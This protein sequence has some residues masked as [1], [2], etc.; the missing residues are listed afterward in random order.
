MK[1]LEKAAAH[2]AQTVVSTAAPCLMSSSR[3]VTAAA[4]A[5][6]LQKDR[7]LASLSA[8]EYVTP[9][10]LAGA[11]IGQHMRHSLDH[12]AKAA[13]AAPRVVSAGVA[14]VADDCLVPAPEEVPEE[15]CLWD[16]SQE[17]AWR[18]ERFRRAEKEGFRDPARG[19]S[20]TV[21]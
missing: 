17:A 11:S 8:L 3:L 18:E 12:L 20:G 4:D 13:D 6:L 9:C 7:L 5:V 21:R 1:L 15:D 16:A 19:N 2:A 10:A 14:G